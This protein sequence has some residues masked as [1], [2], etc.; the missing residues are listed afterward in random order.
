M[1]REQKIVHQI[2]TK[3][4]LLPRRAVC[5]A[6]VA[7]E[8]V[9]VFSLWPSVADDDETKGA[10]VLPPTEGMNRKKTYTTKD[11]ERILRQTDWCK[12]NRRVL[13]GL[14]RIHK[15]K[16]AAALHFGKDVR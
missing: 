14:A 8:N 11:L 3:Q 7:S 5:T 2:Q 15:E 12:F 4:I 6:L 16:P 13:L 9:A 1:N 10:E